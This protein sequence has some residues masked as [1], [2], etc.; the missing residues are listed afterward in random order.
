MRTYGC[1]RIRTI[2]DG[3]LAVCGLPIRTKHHTYKLVSAGLALLEQCTMPEEIMAMLPSNNDIR[4]RIGLHCGPLF[5]GIV[6]GLE[7][8]QY[9][10]YGDTAN[11]ASRMES[12]GV[13]GKVH[14]S[15]AVKNALLSSE[16]FIFVPREPLFIKGKGYMQTYFV[17][18]NSNK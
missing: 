12:N 14:C 3:Y 5:A 16:E 6:G 17:E 4:V 13:P 10:I 1:E 9:D 18:K 15:E 11:T 8:W 7:K 2:G